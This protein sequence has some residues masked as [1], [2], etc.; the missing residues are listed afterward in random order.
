MIY[1][2]GRYCGIVNALTQSPYSQDFK[3]G[4]F[5]PGTNVGIITEDALNFITT[6]NLTIL[7]TEG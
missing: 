4:T 1:N 5:F 2:S 7:I 6:E 3:D